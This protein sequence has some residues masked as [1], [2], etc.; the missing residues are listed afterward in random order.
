MKKTYQAPTMDVVVLQANMAILAGSDQ[1][2]GIGS[3]YSG[4]DIGGR[5]DDGD[6]W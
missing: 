3:D 5:E 6:D 2:M 4:G 1:N